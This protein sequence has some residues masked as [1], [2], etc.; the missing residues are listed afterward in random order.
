MAADTYT[1]RTADSSE[2]EPGRRGR[3]TAGVQVGPD[4]SNSLPPRNN[5]AEGHGATIAP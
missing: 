4:P 5:H 2:P 1:I 3:L